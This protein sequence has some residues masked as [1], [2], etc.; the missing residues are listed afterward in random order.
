[1]RRVW[2][3]TAAAKATLSMPRAY[4]EGS[5]MLSYP[6]DSAAT[7]MARQCSQLLARPG[8]GTPRNS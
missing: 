8:S 5:R 6:E 1:M 3:A 7:V 2:V 4:P